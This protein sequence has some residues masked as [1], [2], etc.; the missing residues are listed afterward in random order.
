M[1]DYAGDEEIEIDGSVVG[2]R[3]F[4]QAAERQHVI[5]QAAP[6]SVVNGL[7]GGC[8]F[9]ALGDSRIVQK[10]VKQGADVVVRKAC[11]GGAQ[12][13]PH[14]FGIARGGGEKVAEF[15]LA[16]FHRADLVDGELGPVV[17]DLE[18][19]FDLDEIVTIEGIHD[20]GDVVPHFG[21][22]LAGAI[23]Q[24]EGEIGLAGALLPDLLRLNEKESGR[25]FV[26]FQVPCEGR[27]HLL[28][29]ES[30]F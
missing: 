6:I 17:V 30:A 29:L 4:S 16:V 13:E 20:F 12:F 22:E 1:Q 7:G 24:Q 2:G 14:L 11:D 15:H 21:V 19:A 3:Q 8:D 9:I 10:R 26:R 18:Q 27:F 25:D 28:G 5:E 23:R